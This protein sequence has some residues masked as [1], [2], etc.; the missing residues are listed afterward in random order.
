MS[1]Q[2]SFRQLPIQISI[3]SSFS[4]LGNSILFRSA[5]FMACYL[6][7]RSFNL[8]ITST[9]LYLYKVWIT[10]V[11]MSQSCLVYLWNKSCF[12]DAAHKMQ[13]I[14]DY[15]LLVQIFSK[16]KFMILTASVTV[17]LK[18]Y[19]VSNLPVTNPLVNIMST[20]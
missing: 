12:G 16:M 17:K 8:Q 10:L 20:H 2:V 5:V 1:P 7:S 11:L 13:I 14:N 3:W 15:T 18:K 6:R 4:S 19:C 9:L